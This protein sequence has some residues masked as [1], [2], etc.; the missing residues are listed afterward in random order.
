MSDTLLLNADG[1][2]LSQIP[3]SVITWQTAMRLVYLGKV[4]VMKEYDEWKV[5]SQMLEVP[6]PSIVIM[7]EMVKWDRQLKYSRSNV[8]LRDDF[9][10]QLQMTNRCQERKGKA[11]LAELTIDHVV[12]RSKGGKTG[13]TNVCTSCKDCNASKGNDGT[14][15]PRRKPIKPSYYEILAKRKTLPLQIR[16][17]A[18]KFYIDWPPEL[19]R[20]L[21]QPGPRG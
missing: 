3:L 19:V 7:T 8:F 14:V 15:V 1:M 21:P 6:V 5:R 18:W 17:E 20:V 16:D 10:C 11:K 12:P 2:P 4:N 9:T 13:W